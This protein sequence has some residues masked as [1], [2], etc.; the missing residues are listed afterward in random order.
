LARHLE[1]HEVL[2]LPEMERNPE[3]YD[4][5]ASEFARLRITEEMADKASCKLLS[6]AQ[7]KANHFHKLVGVAL[8]KPP[9]NVSAAAPKCDG[10]DYSKPETLTREQR[11]ERIRLIRS[12]L[13][14]IELNAATYTTNPWYAAAATM[15]REELIRLMEIED[16]YRRA[17]NG[18]AGG[19]ALPPAPY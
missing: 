1:R 15:G 6:R 7:T 19:R 11:L 3:M 8:D 2:G 9:P 4:G 5:W 10:P 16:E 18:H 12:E 13:P 17:R 14:T